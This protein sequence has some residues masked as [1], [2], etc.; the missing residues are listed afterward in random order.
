[1]TMQVIVMVAMLMRKLGDV[2]G[3]VLMAV[4]CCWLGGVLL[5][6][7]RPALLCRLRE[8]HCLLEYVVA[9]ALY[10][11]H[12]PPHNRKIS[13]HPA[14]TWDKCD[15]RLATDLCSFYGIH[16]WK[17]IKISHY[18]L[19]AIAWLSELTCMAGHVW[20]P[21]LYKPQC[22]WHSNL[23]RH[24]SHLYFCPFWWEFS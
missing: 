7:L 14:C 24:L 23:T 18:F 17:R 10:V 8:P 2:V 20:D 6:L 21:R 3:V 13:R 19:E 1:M 5:L 11:F 16:V 22:I 4:V 9:R 12:H 15:V